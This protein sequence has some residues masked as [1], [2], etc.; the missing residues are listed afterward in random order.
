MNRPLGFPRLSWKLLVPLVMVMIV[1]TT[2]CPLWGGT[3]QTTERSFNTYRYGKRSFTCLVL[4]DKLLP[5]TPP[6]GSRLVGNGDP[7]TMIWP[8]DKAT[9]KFQAADA[10]ETLLLAGDNWKEPDSEAKTAWTKAAVSKLP[11]GIELGGP[12][13]IEPNILPVNG[14]RTG[15]VTQNYTVGGQA[16]THVLVLCRCQD[17]FVLSIALDASTPEAPDCRK[18]LLGMLGAANLAPRMDPVAP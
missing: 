14:W 3:L 15:A 9:A 18:A 5:L 6:E 8:G 12:A 17:G 13:N 1:I 2:G 16:Y 11:A 7:L 4:E 10:R